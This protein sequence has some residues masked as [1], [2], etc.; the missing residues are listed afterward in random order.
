MDLKI[1]SKQIRYINFLGNEQKREKDYSK[2]RKIAQELKR[3]IE[4]MLEILPED[5]DMMIK[6]MFANISLDLCEDAK[7]IG[8]ELLEKG[9]D[10]R[11]VLN[12]L[13][14]AAEKN[15]DYQEALLFLKQIVEKEPN[16]EYMIS[17]VQ[18]VESKQNKK[19]ERSQ[20]IQSKEYKY[21]QIADLERQIRKLAEKEQQEIITRRFKKRI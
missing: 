9:I 15:G 2:K 10:T 7:K 12:G 4:E 5:T 19:E 16:N 21:K 14:I 13:A 6:L 1:V 8:Y 17:K 3:K 18:R 20:Y 11:N